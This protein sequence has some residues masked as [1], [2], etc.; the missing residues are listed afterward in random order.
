MRRTFSIEAIQGMPPPTDAS[1]S[2]PA[3]ETRAWRA[4]SSKWAATTAL[5]EVTTLLPAASASMINVCAGSSPPMHSTTRSIS[6]SPTIS[7]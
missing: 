1:M 5:L 4:N 7:R 2:R 3:P 6:P